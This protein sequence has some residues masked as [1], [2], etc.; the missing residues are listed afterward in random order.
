MPNYLIRVHTTHYSP[1]LVCQKNTAGFVNTLY[2]LKQHVSIS[3]VGA[4]KW[5]DKEPSKSFPLKT[6]PLS[7]GK[8]INYIKSL[9][10]VEKKICEA[11]CRSVNFYKALASDSHPLEKS[12]L[13][14]SSE[15]PISLLYFIPYLIGIP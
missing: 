12:I 8:I 1:R 7:H 15:F 9:W 4:S 3:V 5:Q 14:S 10:Y 13:Y 2:L 11:V 6:F